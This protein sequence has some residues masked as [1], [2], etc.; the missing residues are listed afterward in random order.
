MAVVEASAAAPV[1]PL[2]WEHPYATD[3][4]VK[5]KI[6]GIIIEKMKQKNDSSNFFKLTSL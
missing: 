6:N 3:V 2:A 4:A 5:R 1:Q